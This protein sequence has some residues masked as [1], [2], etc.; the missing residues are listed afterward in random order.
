[1]KIYSGSYDYICKGIKIDWNKPIVLWC[2]QKLRF[3]YDK[4]TIEEWGCF[5]QL[6]EYEQ[7]DK[8]CHLFL[9]LKKDQDFLNGGENYELVRKTIFEEEENYQIY[10]SA[11]GYVSVLRFPIKGNK[12]VWQCCRFLNQDGDLRLLWYPCIF[13]EE[14]LKELEN[15]KAERQ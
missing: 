6:L 11:G 7:N 3:E 13:S 8:G 15:L 2:D 12:K 1:M 10:I 14:F 4:A 5:K 9:R